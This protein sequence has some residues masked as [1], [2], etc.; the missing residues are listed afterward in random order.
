MERNN[1]RPMTTRTAQRH[2]QLEDDDKIAREW[3]LEEDTRIAAKL[4][5][6]WE[7]GIDTDWRIGNSTRPNTSKAGFPFPN[8]HNEDALDD[9][10]D[11]APEDS[12][13][14]YQQS[15]N[16]TFS[17]KDLDDLSPSQQQSPMMS[18]GLDQFEPSSTPTSDDYYA[19]PGISKKPPAAVSTAMQQLV[20]YIG[21]YHPENIELDPILKC[22][23][24]E[25]LP[26][27]PDPDPMMKV[28]LPNDD[29]K[30]DGAENLDFAGVPRLGLTVLDEPS[31]KQSDPAALSLQLRAL[32]KSSQNDDTMAVKTID[33]PIATPVGRKA[34]QSWVSSVNQMHIKPSETVTYSKMMPDLEDLMQRWPQGVSELLIDKESL[35]IDEI[36]LNLKDASQLVL[37]LMDIPVHPV[38]TP[39]A[40]NKSS[41]RQPPVKTRQLI[42]SLH[43]LF[44]LYLE[45]DE[46]GHFGG[47]L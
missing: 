31:T 8:D 42:E 30:I 34:L 7:M 33:V 2:Q 21:A 15:R 1:A 40:S 44:S 41:G 32:Q 29:P 39:A 26:A 45:F 17:N 9:D 37:A 36:D 27:I 22:F 38:K 4:Q 10:E 3:A 28:P 6:D 16:M 11:D 35:G 19:I 43:V 18:R 13:Y 46:H 14:P 25:F 24:P 23:I 20:A 47:R 12:R 5:R